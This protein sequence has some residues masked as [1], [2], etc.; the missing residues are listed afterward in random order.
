MI[1]PERLEEAVAGTHVVAILTPW[2]DYV[3][4]VPT[5]ALGLVAEANVTAGRD[6]SDPKQWADAGWT[7]DG[8]SRSVPAW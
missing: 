2:Q 4:L 1:V 7:N 6:V 5:K 8:A 3:D